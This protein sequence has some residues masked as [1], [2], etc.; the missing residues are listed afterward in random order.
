MSARVEVVK[1]TETIALWRRVCGCGGD[2]RILSVVEKNHVESSLMTKPS[3]LN[4]RS[5][6][7]NDALAMSH[8]WKKRLRYLN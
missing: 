8:I 5:L 2:G 4:N 1:K 3:T 7:D 6:W